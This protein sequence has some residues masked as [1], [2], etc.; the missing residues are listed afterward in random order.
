MKAGTKINHIV[1]CASATAKEHPGCKVHLDIRGP[2]DIHGIIKGNH[3]LTLEQPGKIIVHHNVG[4]DTMIVLVQ[5]WSKGL[6]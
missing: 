3:S 1:T 5:D 6:V 4:L 2:I